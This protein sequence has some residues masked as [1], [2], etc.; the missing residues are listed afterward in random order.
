M[1]SRRNIIIFLFIVL[2]QLVIADYCEIQLAQCNETT[3]VGCAKFDIP[4]TWINVTVVDM[5]AKLRKQILENINDYRNRIA[6]GKILGFPKAANMPVISWKY[7][8]EFLME[9]AA[10]R[11]DHGVFKC[12]ATEEFP[13]PY[14]MSFCHAGNYTES[15][16]IDK[17]LKKFMK[18]NEAPSS[19]DK[20]WSALFMED[21]YKI[22]CAY[23]K[24][25]EH[26]HQMNTIKCLVNR[27]AARKLRDAYETGE[28]CSNC[29]DEGVCSDLYPGLCLREV[30]GPSGP[31]GPIGPPGPPGLSCEAVCQKNS[32]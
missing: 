12:V 11:L 6:T 32:V 8:F 24:Y 29:S 13:Y 21:N 3:H 23:V 16:F 28:P 27:Y 30:M 22:G 10:S 19:L 7:E 18:H 20:S 14:E 25:K 17:A 2:H 1:N 31:V 4:H 15:E 26:G 5:S 9:I